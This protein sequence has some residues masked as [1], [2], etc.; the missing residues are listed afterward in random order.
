L[1]LFF[2]YSDI[3][4]ANYFKPF[5][6]KAKRLNLFINHRWFKVIQHMRKL[7]EFGRENTVQ[8]L[9]WR[10]FWTTVPMKV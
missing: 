3:Y 1:K 7:Y 2:F 8:S 4:V 6:L 10:C 5:H 9:T